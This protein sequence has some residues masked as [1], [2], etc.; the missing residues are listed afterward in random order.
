LWDSSKP[1]Q[2]AEASETSNPDGNVAPAKTSVAI[3][4]RIVAPAK[5][6][7]VIQPRAA[8]FE[9]SLNESA[10]AAAPEKSPVPFS[11]AYVDGSPY[12]AKPGGNQSLKGAV[13]ED[14]GR[15]LD[16]DGVFLVH[17]SCVPCQCF[18]P[19]ALAALRSQCTSSFFDP[20]HFPVAF[21]VQ[22]LPVR[23]RREL[24]VLDLQ[25]Q[26]RFP[27]HGKVWGVRIPTLPHRK[28]QKGTQFA[29]RFNRRWPRCET[30]C[31][32]RRHHRAL[33]RVQIR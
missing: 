33:F 16:V 28:M 2:A 18:V 32:Q 1:G 31:E 5:I 23:S 19:Q 25:S 26:C 24:Q 8:D 11:P 21:T 12:A 20:L 29:S 9:H 22:I 10:I 7:P 27:K 3:Q 14:G 13:E 4:P 30:K 15:N 6:S 17:A